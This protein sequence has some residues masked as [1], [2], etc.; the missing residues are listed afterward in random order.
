[1]LVIHSDFHPHM[2]GL[3][4]AYDAVKSVC[5]AYRVY[6]STP[7]DTKP[8]TFR[9]SSPLALKL[10]IFKSLVLGLPWCPGDDYLVDHSIY[11]YLMDPAGQ[12]AG[13]FGKATTAEEVKKQYDEAVQEWKE[14]HPGWRKGTVPMAAPAKAST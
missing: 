8:G 4:G 7:P 1:M 6:F 14:E 3:T 9:A 10:I 2:I 13:A 5:K 12:F 11:F